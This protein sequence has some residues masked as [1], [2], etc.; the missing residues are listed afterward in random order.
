MGNSYHLPHM[1]VILPSPTLYPT[2]FPTLF[3]FLACN[4]IRINGYNKPPPSL[5]RQLSF[6][7][8]G[9][10]WWLGRYR[11]CL[12]CRRPRFDPWFGKIP[13]RRE[14]LPSSVIL[15]EEFHGQRC[16]AGYSPWSHKE[17]DM[18]ERLTLFRS[19]TRNRGRAACRVWRRMGP[20]LR[21]WSQPLWVPR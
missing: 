13:W 6:D 16:L 4:G 12:Q 19:P 10:P 7:S 11:I 15:P 18:T 17:M 8:G 14:W 9:L 5:R 2:Q 3:H 20:G 1:L 21:N